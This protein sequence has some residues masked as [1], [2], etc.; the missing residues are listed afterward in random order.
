[1]NRKSFFKKLGIGVG[2]AITAPKMIAESLANLKGKPV[3]KSIADNEF[4]ELD[5]VYF[6]GHM[7]R[8]NKTGFVFIL[9]ETQNPTKSGWVKGKCLNP[10]WDK[11]YYDPVVK[12]HTSTL[13]LVGSAISQG[14]IWAT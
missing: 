10:Y 3:Y 1:M 13:E 14:V 12:F 11:F 9:I 6:D 5:T 4:P 2:V 8:H 7:V